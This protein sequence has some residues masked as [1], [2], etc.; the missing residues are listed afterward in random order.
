MVDRAVAEEMTRQ[1][2]AFQRGGGG[3]VVQPGDRGQ[4]AYEIWLDLGNVGT[5]QDFI[6]FLRAPIADRTVRFTAAGL[7]YYDLDD[8]VWRPFSVG[9]GTVH[10]SYS[11]PFSFPITL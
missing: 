4:S 10:P 1:L 9:S 5:E 8:R 11:F 6:D 7:E 3:T 2:Q